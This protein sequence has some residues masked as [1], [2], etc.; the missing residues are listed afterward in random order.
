[1]NTYTKLDAIKTLRNL[2]YVKDGDAKD[3][4]TITLRDAK[5]FVEGVMAMAQSSGDSK[6]KTLTSIDNS[7]RAAGDALGNCSFVPA[8]GL[9]LETAFMIQAE[10]IKA[11]K[12][13]AKLRVLIDQA[14]STTIW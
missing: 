1:M 11:R 13:V 9:N 10:L 3:N 8:N 4:P 5:D 12:T 6:D 7:V 2:S 14:R